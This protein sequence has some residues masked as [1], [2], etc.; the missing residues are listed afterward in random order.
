M[1]ECFT[2]FSPNEIE[3]CGWLR[4]QLEI[5]AASLAGNLDLIWPDIKYSAWIGGDKDNWERFP[6]WLDSALLLAHLTRNQALV[7][8]THFYME[9]ILAG[10]GDDGWICP[11]PEEKRGEYDMWAL[12]MFSK[13][14]VTYAECT[15]DPRAEEALR[16]ALA[17]FNRHLDIHKLAHW[18]HARWFETMLAIDWLQRRR[19]E[20]WL[21]DLARK[22]KE[23]GLDYVAL[24]DNWPYQ[25]ATS[26]YKYES[27]VVDMGM[28]LRAGLLV[29]RVLP[30]PAQEAQP[31][32]LLELLR[33]YHG[34]V[35]GH[36][37]GSEH[38]AGLSPIQ[39]TELCGVAEA[40]FSEELQLADTGDVEWGDW[41]ERLAFNAFPATCSADMW[42]HQYLQQPNQTSCVPQPQKL[43]TTNWRPEARDASCFGLQPYY[44]C[45]TVN[46]GQAWPRL[47][48]AAFMKAPD[49]IFSG[50]L[51]PAKVTT[52]IGGVGVQCELKTAYP[53]RDTLE[54]VV[55]CD[56]PVE[57]TLH[58]RIP[59]FAAAARVD[60]KEVPTGQIVAVRRRWAG[61]STVTVEL[62]FKAELVERPYGGLKALVRGPLVFALPIAAKWTVKEYTAG[63]VERKFPF[64]DYE[65]RPTEAWNYAFA[66]TADRCQ[67]G[68]GDESS[69]ETPFGE[70]NP[71][72]WLTVD[73]VPVPWS[74]KEGFELICNEFPDRLMP[75][76][77]VV[78]KRLIP[79]GC[80]TLR[81]TEMPQVES[82]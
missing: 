57:F 34:M 65:I 71:P 70:D 18:G 4:K 37:A 59:K 16:K 33:R 42:T 29:N 39:G 53:F 8:R 64:C 56:A 15:G 32:R 9:R 45:C 66:E 54:Y 81:M 79:Y 17:Q 25:Q 5:Q 1:Q 2:F 38:L 21:L 63:G 69:L 30:D 74:Y 58:V 77:P 13:V 50:V 24:C 82:K 78:R 60:G 31:R 43:W 3:P 47:A 48:H 68:H 40:M 75:L 11:C 49:G 27:H 73:M 51:M 35:H 7:N 41:L 72:V 28:A 36:F 19:P 55:V 22:L 26:D 67:I 12:E 62:D 10:Q 6:Y 14:L 46:M 76:G 61:R 80:T 23:Q 20:P 52:S 44:G